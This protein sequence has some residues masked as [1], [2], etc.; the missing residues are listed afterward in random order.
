[1]HIQPLTDELRRLLQ[2]DLLTCEIRTDEEKVFFFVRLPEPIRKRLTEIA[3]Q[4]TKGTKYKP[5]VETD[6]LTLLYIPRF[7]DGVSDK[8]R[9]KIIAAAKKIAADNPPLTATLQGFAYFD[10][11]EGHDDKPS[12]ALVGLWDTP[13]LAH[14]HV[15]LHKA[16][17]ELGIEAKQTHGF[18]P[19]STLAYLPKGGRIPKLPILEEHFQIDSFEMSNDRYYKFPLKKS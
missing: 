7:K 2:G 19:H 6:H 14:I 12:T 10:G 9:G 16:I 18:T 5:E 15:A 4:I 11:A 13:G 17:M 1:M 3:T 8:I